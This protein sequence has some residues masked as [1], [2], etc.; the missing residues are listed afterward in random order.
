LVV[1]K[2]SAS[3]MNTHTVLIFSL[4]LILLAPGE[5]KVNSCYVCGSGAGTTDTACEKGST[6]MTKV[7]CP[8]VEGCL[9]SVTVA[10]G[11]SVWVRSCCT[12]G[13]CL[14]KHEKLPGGS[15]DVVSCN[16]DNCNTM[17]P[18]SGSDLHHPALLM[19]S[20]SALLALWNIR[21]E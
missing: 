16:K 6:S 18:R 20:F 13:T 2:L 3:M 21:C 14:N 15:V 12:K 9:A 7:S 8:G 10:G 19:V 4:L 17:D 5:A 11:K 1:V